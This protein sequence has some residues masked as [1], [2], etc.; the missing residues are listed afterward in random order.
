MGK[1]LSYE[2]VKKRVESKGV[3]LISQH[4]K[5]ETEPLIVQCQCGAE[6]QTTYASIRGAGRNGTYRC[7]ECVKVYSRNKF[8][9]S[10]DDIKKFFE[11][12][13]CV[14]LTVEEEYKNVKSNIRFIARCGHICETS[15][16]S[17]RNSKYKMCF[18]CTK[19]KY[20]G[21]NSYNWK[22]GYDSEN[23]KFRKTYAFKK[24]VKSVYK[25]DKYTCQ[26]CGQVGAKLNAHHLNGYNWDIENRLNVQN[27]ITLCEKCH[28]DFHNIYGRGNNT[29]EQFENW[30]KED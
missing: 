17:Y 25:R 26:K 22:G 11:E 21:E 4:Y 16:D 10:Y 30:I 8:R 18:N 1:Y 19:E 6:I 13:G 24:W 27:G 12:N 7:R 9:I 2:E 5:G 3:R 29:K 23:E 15:F 28:N 20:S 14:L